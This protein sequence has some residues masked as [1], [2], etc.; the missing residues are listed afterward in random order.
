MSDSETESL[1]RLVHDW[2]YAREF[3]L[4]TMDP[5][6]IQ[7]H[8]ELLLS[9]SINIGRIVAFVGAGVSMSYGRISWRELV[10][11]L[12]ESAK[13][14]YKKSSPTFKEQ[15]PRIEVIYRTLEA[16]KPVEN[17]EEDGAWRDMPSAR[18]LILFQIADELGEA[19]HRSDK[20]RT[21]ELNAV[22]RDARQLVYDDAAHARRLLEA[23]RKGDQEPA[24]ETPIRWFKKYLDERSLSRNLLRVRPPYQSIFSKTKLGEIIKEIPEE[25]KHLKE[26]CS[27]FQ[28]SNASEAR[29]IYLNPT[30][31]FVTAAALAS[32]DKP[33]RTKQL[34]VDAENYLPDGQLATPDQPA[35]PEELPRFRDESVDPTRDP[36]QLMVNRL[37]VRRFITTNYDLDIE[38]MMLDR[39]YRLR[40][41]GRREDIPDNNFIAES[42]NAIEARARDF[43]FKGERAAHL[44]DFAVQDG[45]FAL[46]VVHL[47]GRATDGDDIVATEADYQRLYLHNESGRGRGRDLLDGAI[48]LAFRGN[49]LLFVGNGMG[50]D[51]LLRPLRHFMSEGPSGRESDAIALLPDLKGEQARLEEKAT[52]LRRYGVYTIHFGQGKILG[53]NKEE[54][55]LSSL[56]ALIRFLVKRIGEFRDGKRPFVTSHATAIADLHKDIGTELSKAG[57]AAKLSERLIVAI[58]DPGQPEGIKVAE[59]DEVERQ[60]CLLIK[61]ELEIID[62]ILD[63]CIRLARGYCAEPSLAAEIRAVKILAE[64]TEDAIVAGF[65]SAIIMRLQGTWAGW[66][67]QWFG[68]ISPRLPIPRS[69]DWIADSSKGSIADSSKWLLSDNAKIDRRRAI[70]LPLDF[71]SA[72]TADGGR[73]R[74]KS[75]QTMAHAR[76]ALRKHA[77]RS[78]SLEVSAMFAS[79]RRVFLLAGPRG[80]GK[81][82]F[83]SALTSG[84][85]LLEFLKVSWND[86]K[87]SA[88]YVGAFAFN[89]SFSVE[90]GSG[91][92]RLARFLRER[93]EAGYGNERVAVPPLEHIAGPQSEKLADRFVRR[94]EE[95]A[96][97]KPEKTA[98]GKPTVPH[99]GH[100]IGLLDFLL[101]VMAGKVAQLPKPQGRFVLLFNATQLLFSAQGFSK[102][103]DITRI[104]NILLDPLY[105]EAEI[106]V[107]FVMDEKGIPIEFRDRGLT[108]LPKEP[109]IPNPKETSPHKWAVEV[110][111]SPSD[112]LRSD[113][114]DQAAITRLG[115][116]LRDVYTPE[117]VALFLRLRPAMLGVVAA[118]AFPRTLAAIVF[119]E[120]DDPKKP[121]DPRRRLTV[122][123]LGALEKAVRC[124]LT[125]HAAEHDGVVDREAFVT[126]IAGLVLTEDGLVK[127][128]KGQIE[129]NEAKINL[130]FANYFKAF[131]GSRFALT[132]AFAAADEELLVRGDTVAAVDTLNKIRDEVSGI[133]DPS[134]EDSIVRAVIAFHRR[135]GV[136]PGPFKGILSKSKIPAPAKPLTQDEAR[137]RDTLLFHRLSEICEELL[138]TLSMI[139]YPVEQDC[140]A[141]LRFRAWDE[142]STELPALDQK[143]QKAMVET[144]LHILVQRCL[145]FRFEAIVKEPDQR[146]G[147]KGSQADDRGTERFGVHRH[148]QRHVFRQLKQPF[149]EHA[150]I[151]SYMPTLYASQPNDLPYPT[152]TAQ[153]R[154]REIV[155]GL[156]RYPSPSRLREPDPKRNDSADLQSRMLRAAY[157][158]IRTVYGVGV[159]ARFHEFGDKSKP[160]AVGYFEEHRQQVRW[161]LKRAKDVERLLEEKDTEREVFDQRLPF[162]SGDIA[163]IYNECGV[164]SLV[165]G[166][167]ND[168]SKLFSEAVRSLNPIER[169]GIPAA[170]T[171]SIRLNRALVDIELGNLRKAEAALRD[172]VAQQDEHRAVRWIAYGY[173]GLIEHIRGNLKEARS[174]YEGALEVLTKMERNRAA[175]IFSRHAADLYR[176]LKGK[177]NLKKAE[178]LA[179]NA[180]NLAAAGS[181]ADVLHQARLSRLQIQAVSKGPPAFAELRKELEGIE[182]YAKVMGMPR[183]EVETA[184]VD[185]HFRHQL[186]D[187]NMAM[188]SI[189]RSLAIANDCDLV[190]RKIG[191]TLL[192]A[193]ISRD[194]GM[195][196]GARTLAETAKVMATTAE[197]SMD[198]DIAQTILA[199]L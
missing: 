103:S 149:V 185:A 9:R 155:A 134:R 196:E 123:Q 170:L 111:H 154:I 194:L 107:V 28:S 151:E 119:V 73:F 133:D 161:L 182:T 93:L 58:G 41:P 8:G 137:R 83:F 1:S 164:L 86:H 30:H 2:P 159:V 148:V 184:Y 7:R 62:Y 189:T 165:Q 128:L 47:H 113:A 104:M 141:A 197:F 84:E 61:S 142:W 195:L 157:G 31:R 139:G 136:R 97:K 140:L 46:D 188:K 120:R 37:G 178:Q 24:R 179:D 80:I 10:R 101:R 175:S 190:L 67:D 69:V 160:P 59:I 63:F 118:A 22:R 91:F 21:S 92:D 51:D 55:L 23:A 45:R 138:V 78:E 156:S 143:V 122:D 106:D 32:I 126:A 88:P 169:R 82:H 65:L 181:H 66:R 167:L 158:V 14:E 77:E 57:N 36:L 199:S 13:Q 17:A 135:R 102:S 125:A 34:Q 168:A 29:T 64:N 85:G 193:K 153:D 81:G 99:S 108:A 186:G 89:F 16:L 71:N 43:V 26:L 116:R 98:K 176:R 100:R 40:L 114:E 95:I 105:S 60:P 147:G 112:P 3:V 166:R 132:I 4:D 163:W 49:A 18:L 39:G 44:I 180:V 90:L 96:G 109:D 35:K 38:Q 173:R 129:P 94:Y 53:A 15:H 70:S 20:T 12:L 130:A 131:G 87:P 124:I 33:E 72:D 192:A 48:N 19:I 150:E 74:I 68:D 75:S 56:V 117:N 187:F 191:G 162:Y 127:H 50:E 52:L 79:G 54:F 174:R 145:V 27:K 171:T 115:L 121:D 177:D 152:I 5:D 76:A 42:V 183:L 25:L 172:I 144:A 146:K 11:E 110:V 6:L 198:Q